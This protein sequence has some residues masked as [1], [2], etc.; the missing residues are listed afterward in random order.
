[1]GHLLESFVAHQLVTLAGWTDP[2]IRF[3]HFRDKDGQEVDLVMTLGNRNLGHG[4]QGDKHARTVG[5]PGN[6][7]PRGAVRE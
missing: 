6:G 4:G 7:A 1:M 2:D 5:G 3:W